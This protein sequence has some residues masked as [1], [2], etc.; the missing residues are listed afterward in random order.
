MTRL[1]NI[2][3][4][5]INT[6][7]YVAGVYDPSGGLTSKAPTIEN[8]DAHMAARSGNVGTRVW[9]QV[10]S[11]VP[12][13]PKPPADVNA[14]AFVSRLRSVTPYASLQLASKANAFLQRTFETTNGKSFTG[15]QL[16][17]D[18]WV[19]DAKDT[20]A[21]L[22]S[23]MGRAPEPSV[24]P[25]SIKV[26]GALFDEGMS[27]LGLLGFGFAAMTR[28][29]I[30]TKGVAPVIKAPAPFEKL[31]TLNHEIGRK[32]KAFKAA[33]TDGEK[34]ALKDE[35]KKLEAQRDNVRQS[36]VPK[37]RRK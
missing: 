19:R 26:G 21:G 37:K 22:L 5:N 17:A 11:S 15:A 29:V 16:L 32:H 7:A 8:L 1:P 36:L 31:S 25:P 10:T 2:E 23:L 30:K 6:H 20:G 18:A 13:H 28:G 24:A 9:N 35:L 33:A 34:M 27:P 12:N 4:R 14:Q 3:M